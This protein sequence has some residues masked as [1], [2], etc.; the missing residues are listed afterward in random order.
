[1]EAIMGKRV[2]VIVTYNESGNRIGETHHNARISDTVVDQVRELHEDFGL[3]YYAIVEKLNLSLTAVRKICTY[4]RRA[5]S[6]KRWKRV[7]L[8]A[9]SLAKSQADDKL[10]ERQE[11]FAKRYVDLYP[12]KDAGLVAA[13]E[14][15]YSPHTALQ[16]SYQLLHNPKIANFITKRIPVSTT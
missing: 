12:R 9:E 11:K 8:T 4:A 13:I 10:T 15:G 5:D 16:I 1:M 14:A 3:G 7:Y 6:Q 2:M